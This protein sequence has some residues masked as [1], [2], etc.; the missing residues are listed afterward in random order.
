MAIGVLIAFAVGALRGHRLRQG[1]IAHPGGSARGVRRRAARGLRGGG[2]PAGPG[3]GGVHRQ[4]PD[5]DRGRGPVMTVR[6]IQPR[7]LLEGRLQGCAVRFIL[8][9]PERVLNAVGRREVVNRLCLGQPFH[10]QVDR[11][12][13]RTPP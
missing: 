5:P 3:P 7:H 1:R 9:G 12:G 4:L 11:A 13:G 2:H 8:D 6:D 10:E